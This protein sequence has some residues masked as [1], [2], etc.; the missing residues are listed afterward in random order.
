MVKEPVIYRIKNIIDNRFYI[1]STINFKTRI[2]KHKT[3]LNN[4]R[5]HSIFLQRAWKKYG[6]NNFV[7]EVIKKNINIKD[8]LKIEQIY[9]DKFK[10][11]KILYNICFVAGNCMGV[12]QSK[13]TLKKRSNT[14]KN[15]KRSKEWGVNISNAKKGIN[16]PGMDKA[17]QLYIDKYTKRLSKNKALILINEYKNG[18]SWNQISKENN[19]SNKT[20]RREIK[21]LVDVNLIPKIRSSN[22]YNRN[23]SIGENHQMAK[24]TEK[25]V[26]YI[27]NNKEHKSI[28]AKKFRIKPCTVYDIK[29][30]RSWRHLNLCQK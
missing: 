23:Y 21:R 4:N 30:G 16:T 10:N 29:S 1:G 19:L 26:I 25:E 2:H 12:K 24:L 15:Y 22:S 18:K 28:I 8:I 7:F 27:F 9:L 5:H 3:D 20:L 13:E 14:M 11:E 6:K 17:R